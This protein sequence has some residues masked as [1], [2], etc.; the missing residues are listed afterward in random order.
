MR[1][2]LK[3]MGGLLKEAFNEWSNDKAVKLGAAL[4]YYTVF[5]LPPLLFIAVAV[6]GLVYGNDAAQGRLV[7]QFQGLVGAD[8][9]RIIQTMIQKASGTGKGIAA[10]AVGLL[11]LL[12]GA[13]GVFGELQDS[14]NTVWGLRLKPGGTIRSILRTRLLS[15][16]MVVSIGF[17]LLVSLVVSAALSALSA[18]LDRLW[19]GPPLVGYLL[20]ALNLIVSF[21]IT[22]LL[23]ALI[24]RVLPDARIAWRD[25]WLGAA[26]TALLF[27][28]G[29][30]LIG[31]YLGRS[32]IGSTY[33][34]AGSLIVLLLWI[35]YSAQ[36]LFFG[37]EFTE[38]YA[39]RYGSGIKPD[40]HA[41]TV[42]IKP[43]PSGPAPKAADKAA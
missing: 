29:K 10:T 8:G 4:A 5:S 16:A 37:A 41:E 19:P 9:A 20:Q 26:F 23:F 27:T 18:Y 40:P 42:E 34:A 15:F 14:L 33:G 39:N 1:V 38:V 28:V 17:I 30:F 3:G 12:L 21:G 31:L 13:G 25:V 6:A 7:E 43:P 32:T 11:F 24:Y 22:T 36:I 2:G 35:Y